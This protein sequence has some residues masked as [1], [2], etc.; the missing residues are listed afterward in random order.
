MTNGAAGAQ[1]GRTLT[2]NSPAP[3]VDRTEMRL[4]LLRLDHRT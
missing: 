1:S 4:D 2:V 3:L